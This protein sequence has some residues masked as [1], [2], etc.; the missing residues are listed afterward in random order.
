MI[1]ENNKED[2]E[3]TC[4][5]C[6]KSFIYTVKDQEF[7]EEHGYQPPKRCKQCRILRQKERERFSKG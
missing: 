2:I 6:G 5:G 3:L 4:V 1:L 7:Y